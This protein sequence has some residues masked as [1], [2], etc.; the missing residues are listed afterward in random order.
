MMSEEKICDNKKTDSEEKE[1]VFDESV[2]SPEF[3]E[4][5]TKTVEDQKD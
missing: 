4:G 3:S 1:I 2:C 5:C